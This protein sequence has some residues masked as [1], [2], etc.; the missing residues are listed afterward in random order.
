MSGIRRVSARPHR[1]D[2]LI[3]LPGVIVAIGIGLALLRSAGASPSDRIRLLESQIRCP[4]CAGTSIEDSPASLAA[5]MRTVVEQ[6]VRSGASDDDVRSFFVDRYGPWILLLPPDGGFALALWLAPV[7]FVAAGG[8]LIV[9]SARRASPGS[10]RGGPLHLGRGRQLLIG[11][12]IAASLGLP[13]ALVAAPRPAGAEITGAS[14]GSAADVPSIANLEAVVASNPTSAEALVALG[15]AN[16]RAGQPAAAVS[17]Y[18][19]ALTLQPGDTA[20]SLALG[21]VLLSNGQAGAA[22]PLFDQVLA[23]DPSQPDA[24][25]YRGLARFQLG[26]APSLVRADALAFLA[27]AGA[28]PRRLIAEQLLDLDAPSPGP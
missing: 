18:E 6:Q 2:L 19:R 23:A 26:A 14:E 20:A 22:E 3:V 13:L 12:A 4:V 9:R 7:L 10:P 17:S 24:L 1:A 25:L 28:D 8:G 21:V 27:V 16:L 15:D 5:D 11:C